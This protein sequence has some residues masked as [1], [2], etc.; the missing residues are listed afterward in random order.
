MENYTKC[1]ICFYHQFLEDHDICHNCG[2]EPGYDDAT[3]THE[4]LREKLA[5]NKNYFWSD[6]EDI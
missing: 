3:Y 2:F 1:P 6:T 5:E 4:E